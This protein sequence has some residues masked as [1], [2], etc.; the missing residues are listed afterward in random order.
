MAAYA[1]VTAKGTVRERGVRLALR[2]VV[3][4]VYAQRGQQNYLKGIQPSV[5]TSR[6][7]LSCS[8]ILGKIAALQKEVIAG[9][10]RFYKQ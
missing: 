8:A 3:V 1:W 6:D 9:F 5:M 2:E 4:A 10:P 7:T